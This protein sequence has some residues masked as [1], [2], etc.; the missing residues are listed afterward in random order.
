MLATSW[1][2]RRLFMAE[3]DNEADGGESP[4]TVATTYESVAS[5]YMPYA[6][7]P[8]DEVRAELKKLIADGH[9]HVC[10]TQF[11]TN[12]DWFKRSSNQS[13]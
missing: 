4:A 12:E 11:L 8:I 5:G 7:F 13:L 6:D 10:A 9:E 1:E 3:I 2:L